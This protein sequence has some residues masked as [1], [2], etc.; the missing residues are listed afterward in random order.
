MDEGFCENL[1]WAILWF[2]TVTWVM[3]TVGKWQVLRAHKH[4]DKTW[5]SFSAITSKEIKLQF[6]VDSHRL[7][8]FMWIECYR[9]VWTLFGG[10]QQWWTEL[11]LSHVRA[12]W[13]H[14]RH[15]F[16]VHEVGV[17]SRE[18]LKGAHLYLAITARWSIYGKHHSSV[19]PCF[20]QFYQPSTQRKDF[21]VCGSLT[22]RMIKIRLNKADHKNFSIDTQTRLL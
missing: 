1:C 17:V 13:N 6:W 4:Y 16:H 10:D 22:T 21:F 7:G 9:R 15:E 8:S 19:P 5:R 14:W 2:L 11:L 3:L 18:R 20:I 12:S